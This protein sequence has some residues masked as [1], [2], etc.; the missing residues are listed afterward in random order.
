M[1]PNKIRKELFWDIS[2]EQLDI[3]RNRRLIIDRVLQYGNLKEFIYILDLYGIEKIKQ[4]VKQIAYLDPK[5]LEFVSGYFN[6]DKKELK[7]FIKKQLNQ[8]HWN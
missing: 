3:Q 6:I 5:T 8:A 4:E 7:C 2:P 1:L